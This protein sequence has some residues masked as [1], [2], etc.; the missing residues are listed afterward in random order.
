MLLFA[1]NFISLQGHS[2][3]FG[4]I[5]HPSSGVQSTESTASVTGHIIVAATAK[6]LCLRHNKFDVHILFKRK[7]LKKYYCN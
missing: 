1:I 4:C 7:T 5:P 6:F 2:T 3:C